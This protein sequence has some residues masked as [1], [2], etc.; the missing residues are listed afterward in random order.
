MCGR[1]KCNYSISQLI[2]SNISSNNNRN[3]SRNN[4]NNTHNN[5]KHNLKRNSNFS[6]SKEYS[7]Q[8]SQISSELNSEVNCEEK[9]EEYSRGN[10]KDIEKYKPMNNMSPGMDFPILLLNKLTNQ[11]VI[12]IMKWGLMN[13]YTKNKNNNTF[14]Y[15][16]IFNARFLFI[17]FLYFYL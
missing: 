13:S 16:K 3:N 7:K 17:F 5:N 9:C 8:N 2:S 10:V 6:T 4:N 12:Y 15:F 14:N 11:R 1:T